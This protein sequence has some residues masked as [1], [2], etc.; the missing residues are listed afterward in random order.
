MKKVIITGTKGFIGGNLKNKISSEF[1]ILEINEDIFDL[2]NW[3][4][5]I[6]KIVRESKASVFFHVGACSNTLETDV[7]YMMS[8]NFEST[9][10][11]SD[12]CRETHI[13]LI[14]SSS[15][16][17]YGDGKSPLNLYAWS[18]LTA[19]SYVIKNWGIALRYFNVYG[20]G[21]D[22]KGK[23]SSVAYQMFN[24]NKKGEE[25]KL[26]PGNPKRDF[27]YVEDVVS[28]NIH[29]YKNYN[30]LGDD[31]YDVGSGEA[32]SFEDVLDILEIKYTH[33]PEYFIPKGYQFYTKSN[34]SKWL[35]FWKPKY[36]L[37][38][39]LEEYKTCL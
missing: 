3:Q 28:A 26:F 9:K 11:V 12:V 14:F 31:W 38:K 13:P 10:V 21:E 29:A 19:E 32:R 39:G 37:E 6:E 24:K 8:R 18:K 17:I 1:E 15:A 20:P 35:P 25:I 16:A 22:H 33:T 23:M 27:V 34:K 4:T 2:H 30:I 7:N 36:V 5:E